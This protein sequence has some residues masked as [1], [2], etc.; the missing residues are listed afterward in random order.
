MAETETEK[1]AR[2]AMEALKRKVEEEERLN[3]GQ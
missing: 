2:E 1:Q 3:G